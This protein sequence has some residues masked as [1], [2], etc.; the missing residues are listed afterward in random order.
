MADTGLIVFA[1]EN[2]TYGLSAYRYVALRSSSLKYGDLNR[3][4]RAGTLS[5]AHPWRRIIGGC[6]Q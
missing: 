2:I 6:I 1:G 3:P 5:M 4:I